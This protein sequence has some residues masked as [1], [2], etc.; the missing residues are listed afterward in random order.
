MT[1]F[2]KVLVFV[3]LTLSLI[4]AA[5]ALGVFTQRVDMSDKK[6]DQ[7]DERTWGRVAK[8]K[9]ELTRWNGA[10]GKTGPRPLAEARWLS[11]LGELRAAEDLRAKNRV[12]Y[13]QELE[14]LEK[15][16]VKRAVY[17]GGD[18]QREAD[19]KPRLAVVND[20]SGQAP[21]KPRTELVKQQAELNTQIAEVQDQLDKLR[22][23]AAVLTNDIEKAF[24]DIGRAA[25]ARQGS[26]EE[27]RYLERVLYNVQVE[28]ELLLDRQRE[29]EARLKEL[30]GTQVTSENK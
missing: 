14:A 18:L 29:L 27:Q 3:N 13:V 8:L 20:K 6:K 11:A 5:W 10:D 12:W 26:V 7:Q 24:R 15:A 19:G 30:K 4:F 9:D 2:G 28:A 22:K 21:L 1:K 17:A 16:G 25:Q 23:Q